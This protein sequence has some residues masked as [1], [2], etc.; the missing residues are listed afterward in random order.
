MRATEGASE[1][2]TPRAKAP[3]ATKAVDEDA[4]DELAPWEAPAGDRAI[5]LEPTALES[6]GLQSFSFHSIALQSIGLQCVAV[7]CN[8]LQTTAIDCI[9]VD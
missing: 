4:R 1:S 5:D 6:I 9:A 2:N 3:E 7:E 8:R